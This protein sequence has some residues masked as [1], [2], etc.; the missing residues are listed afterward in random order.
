[1]TFF[2]YLD[3]GSRPVIVIF[4]ANHS[5]KLY[6]INWTSFLFDCRY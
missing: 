5:V 4:A 2:I 1:M 3:G 6:L